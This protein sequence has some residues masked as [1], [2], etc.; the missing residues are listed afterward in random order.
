MAI[1]YIILVVLESQM[2]HTKFQGN[3]LGGSGE[4][5]LFMFLT[6]LGMMAIFVM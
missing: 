5:D 2:L 6:Y 1:I 3:Q 4:A